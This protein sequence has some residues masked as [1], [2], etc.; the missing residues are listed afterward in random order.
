M[1]KYTVEKDAVPYPRIKYNSECG[2]QLMLIEGYKCESTKDSGGGSFLIR[3]NELNL[4]S[5]KCRKCGVE[6]TTD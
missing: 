5:G 2:Y 1:C 3:A 6:I 4:P